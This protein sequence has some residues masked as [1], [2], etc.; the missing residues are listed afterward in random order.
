MV[1]ISVEKRSRIYSLVREG[2]PSCYV[3]KKE[4]VSQLSVVRI[5][6]KA[7]KTG[8]VKDLPKSGRP[9]V[10]TERDERSIVRLLASGECFNAVEIK[11][12]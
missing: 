4:G 8:S 10:F 11:K 7:V 9:R 1:R 2:Y 12:K 5:N 6:Q 3:A